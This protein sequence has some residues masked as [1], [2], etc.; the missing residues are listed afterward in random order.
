[1][2]VRKQLIINAD[3]FGYTP[4][5]THGIIEAHNKGVVTSTTALTVSPYFEEAMVLRNQL[6][7]NLAVGVH[8]A[9]T[10][11]GGKPLLAKEEVPSLVDANGEFL[12]QQE[13]ADK[14]DLDDVYRE[15]DAQIARFYATGNKPDHLDSHHDVHVK[16]RGLWDVAVK[17]SEKYAL[18]IRNTPILEHAAQ[19]A[20]DAQ[21]ITTDRMLAGFYGV[22]STAE[23]LQTI[24][25]DVQGNPTFRTYEMSCHPAF[26][27]QALKQGSSYCDIRMDELVILTDATLPEALATRNIDL[28]TY[29]DLAQLGTKIHE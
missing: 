24:L 17:L 10:L 3:D 19:V 13:V 20:Q 28:I 16:T 15:W 11:K 23:N 29:G 26:I 21:V 8:L 22:G 6:A 9:L 7:P 4:G 14:V 27:D 18:P 25:D 1:M 2:K 5:V 12:T